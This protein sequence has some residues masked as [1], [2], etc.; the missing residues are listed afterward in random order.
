M[1]IAHR[2]CFEVGGHPQVAVESPIPSSYKAMRQFF[3]VADLVRDSVAMVRSTTDT[4][5]YAAEEVASRLS[6]SKLF[7]MSTHWS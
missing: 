2:I 5:A 3:S 4:M 1:P 6:P 7:R